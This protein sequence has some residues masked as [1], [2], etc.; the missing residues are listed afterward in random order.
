VDGRVAPV[1]RGI[2]SARMPLKQAYAA[3][4]DALLTAETAC[5][6]AT[7]RG[8]AGYP[9]AELEHAWRELLRNAPH[10][11]VSGCSVDETHA[12]MTGRF[13][14]VNQISSRMKREAIAAL[15]GKEARWS[16]REA[17]GDAYSV[18]NLLPWART[19]VAEL[20]LP[21]GTRDS[22]MATD[23]TGAPALTQRSNHDRGKAWALLDLPSF[24]ATTVQLVSSKDRSG[25]NVGDAYA[26]GRRI[27]NSLVAIVVDDDGTLTITDRTTGESWERSHVFEDVADRGD[28]YNFC[29]VDGDEPET[30]AGTLI[31]CTVVESG[32]LVAELA[33][34]YELDLPAS[35]THERAR[36]SD[37]RVRC[38]MTTRVRLV[39]ASRRVVF[40]TQIDN[41]ALDHRLRVRFPT[42][43][44]SRTVIAEGA[45]ALLER[46]ACPISDGV[47]WLE[48]PSATQ[49]TRGLV[50]AGAI[51]VAGRGLPEYEAIVTE[52]GLDI[53]LT[54]LRC[55]GWLSREDLSSRPGGA[56]PSL[57]VPDAQCLGRHEF[58]Y[59]LW[60]GDADATQRLRDAAE[61]RRPIAV[62]EEGAASGPLLDVIGY[63]FAD[64]ALKAAED[65]DGL[66]LR[67][68]AGPDGGCVD[69]PADIDATECRLDEQPYD[70]PTTTRGGPYV[71]SPARIASWRLR[72][73]T[74]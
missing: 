26:D 45:F 58:E 27:E 23:G 33:L 41:G 43:V 57:E 60:V 59:A 22:V 68:F 70:R 42:L 32:P 64:A 12:A 20:A 8:G 36:R 51:A 72:R 39:A 69:L 29:P 44:D 5:A 50:A 6:L 46:S 18:V 25:D 62:G 4:E 73:R 63:G 48:P 53:A 21:P 10:D 31:D 11:S 19:D 74:A 38:E 16:Y 9:H 34:R 47:G 55:V 67:V 3:A 52:T 54:L 66:I 30:S 35:L 28:E 37:E 13:A 61:W 15:A 17:V 56:G 14:T 1:L 40:K 49:H 24:G 71:L 65:G 7:L 2:N